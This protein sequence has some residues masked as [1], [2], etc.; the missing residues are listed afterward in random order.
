MNKS[1][2]ILPCRWRGSWLKLNP[3]F[4]VFH[5]VFSV[6]ILL[7]IEMFSYW[8]GN[9]C[10][11]TLCFSTYVY[12]VLFHSQCQRYKGYISKISGPH[13]VMNLHCTG[14]SAPFSSP[15]CLLVFIERAPGS[16]STGLLSVSPS[17]PALDLLLPAPVYS[18]LLSKPHL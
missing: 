13:S 14:L 12:I 2:I 7:V 5:S 16:H 18:A 9:G 3:S 15:S 1:S 4:P 17:P 6:S 8:K 11:G 10:G